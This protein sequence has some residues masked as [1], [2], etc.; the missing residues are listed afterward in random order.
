MKRI[1][2]VVLSVLIIASCALLF[3]SCGEKE[4]DDVP[5][6]MKLASDENAA[7]KFF[8]PSTWQSDVKS[9]ATTAYYSITDTSSVS[10]M[11]FSME[12]SDDD[13]STWWKS[14]LLDFNNVYEDFELVSEEEYEL[15]GEAAER[16][17]FLGTL[18]LFV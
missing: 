13:V 10:V 8:V 18:S 7:Y 2:S 6:G 4:D 9:G 3:A 17:V 1:L 15:D 11:V 14:F 5:K 12:H 16:Y